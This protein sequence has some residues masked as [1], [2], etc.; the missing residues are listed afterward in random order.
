MTHTYYVGWRGTKHII[1]IDALNRKEAL[2]KFFAHECVL[3]SSMAIVYKTPVSIP[4]A[5]IS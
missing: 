2:A 4:I 1:A 3:P 5:T